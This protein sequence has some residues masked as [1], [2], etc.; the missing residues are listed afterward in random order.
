MALFDA[1]RQL[2]HLKN[3]ANQNHGRTRSGDGQIGLP[4]RIGIMLH[5]PRH[6]HETQHI[7]GCKS[8]VETNQ[9]APKCTFTPI[10]VEWKADCLR[11]PVAIAR[12]KA[13]Q[14]AGDQHVVEM[15]DQKQAV[16]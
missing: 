8:K 3:D 14:R 1:H 15:G 16:V 10:F 5:A 6:T 2:Y 13:E 7:Q 4:G 11:E 12:E 9:P